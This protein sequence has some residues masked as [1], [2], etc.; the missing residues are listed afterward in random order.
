MAGFLFHNE[1]AVD[2]QDTTEPEVYRQDPVV[3][4]YCR[5]DLPSKVTGMTPVERLRA[6]IE[7]AS[8]ANLQQPELMASRF[9]EAQRRIADL[10]LAEEAALEAIATGGTKGGGKK[11][12]SY[13]P[14]IKP[15]VIP[16]QPKQDEVS[17][18]T[19]AA[20]DEEANDIIGINDFSSNK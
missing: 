8:K 19:R 12:S 6:N 14:H 13:P 7:A 11:M 20:E 17:V 10:N 3:D 18:A 4:A 16:P 5:E 1:V 15:L 2:L 9:A